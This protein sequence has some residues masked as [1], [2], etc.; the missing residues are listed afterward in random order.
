MN[1]L[2]LCAIV[3]LL[4]AVIL[5][6]GC[7]GAFDFTVDLIIQ[8]HDENHFE[9]IITVQTSGTNQP[10]I[11]IAATVYY[12]NINNYWNIFVDPGLAAT[13]IQP[14]TPTLVFDRTRELASG[15]WNIWVE[16]VMQPSGGNSLLVKSNTVQLIV[17]P[18][19]P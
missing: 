11:I 2:K 15:T 6:S 4:S 19:P 14:N 16:I 18:P 12:N 8:T 7:I 10:A 17:P 9:Y 5:L 13:I 1:R 3:P